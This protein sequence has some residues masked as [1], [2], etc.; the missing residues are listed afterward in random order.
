MYGA[1]TPLA[2]GLGTTLSLIVAIGSQ[3]AFVLRQGL[4]RE[5]VLL[6]VAIC[7][8]SDAVLI[9]LGISG[10][11]GV[12]ALWPSAI[13]VFGWAGAVFLAGYGLY[14]AR[15]A[16]RPEAMQASHAGRSSLRAALLTCLAFTWI[17]PHVYLDTVFLLGSIGNSYGAGR[18]VFAVGSVAG[19]LLWFTTLGFGAR[20]LSGVFTRPM[21]WRVL[22]SLIAATMLTLGIVMAVRTAS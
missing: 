18:W 12:I 10:I 7:G 1:L 20:A 17:N 4:R 9:T 15:R 13:T 14:A 22:D 21:A 19:S 16:L 3:N 5:H 8:A 11:G 2:A 6:V